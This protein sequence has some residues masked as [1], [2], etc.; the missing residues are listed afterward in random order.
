[1]KEDDTTF[2]HK[3]KMDTHTEL[4]NEITRG[5]LQE[6]V[7]AESKINLA[8]EDSQGKDREKHLDQCSGSMMRN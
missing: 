7:G 3:G 4:C 8:R 6:H 5:Q 2:Y 1:M